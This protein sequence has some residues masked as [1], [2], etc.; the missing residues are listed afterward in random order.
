MG[1]RA[2]LKARSI[3]KAAGLL[4]VQLF[5]D[6]ALEKFVL[7]G[8]SLADLAMVTRVVSSWPWRS[9]ILGLGPFVPHI[10]V[11]AECGED[12]SLEMSILEFASCLLYYLCWAHMGWYE[13]PLLCHVTVPWFPHLS[14][15]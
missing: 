5:W 1:K 15:S 14:Q 7:Q 12:V 13:E 3:C 2:G 11:Q 8:E 4:S 10:C 9:H 6:L